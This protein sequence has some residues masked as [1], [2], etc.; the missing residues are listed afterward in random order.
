MFPKTFKDD[1]KQPY[2]D[3]SH[4]AHHPLMQTHSGALAQDFSKDPIADTH[5]L[6]LAH[7]LEPWL[8]EYRVHPPFLHPLSLNH[9][10]H[11]SEWQHIPILSFYC[12]QMFILLP[13]VSFGNFNLIWVLSFLTIC[14]HAQPMSLC[15]FV[16]CSHFHQCKIICAGTQDM[17]SFSLETGPQ[18]FV[19]VWMNYFWAW[20]RFLLKTCIASLLQQFSIVFHCSPLFRHNLALN[21]QQLSLPSGI[22]IAFHLLLH[23]LPLCNKGKMLTILKI[24]QLFLLCD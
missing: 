13:L 17:H 19:N 6:L 24:C 20:R 12:R 21:Q 10:P 22:Q 3:I 15:S 4:L 18:F 2:C 23:Y 11:L 16:S 7:L 9:P 1:R 5:L 14:L 8:G